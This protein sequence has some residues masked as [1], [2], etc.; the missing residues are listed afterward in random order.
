MPIVAL[1][2]CILIGWCVG[3]KSVEDEVTRNGEKFVRRAIYRV[4]IRYVSPV[5]LIVILVFYTLATFGIISF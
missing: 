3:T 4:M 2:T 5:C 1:C